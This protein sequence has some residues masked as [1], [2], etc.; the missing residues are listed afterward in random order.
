MEWRTQGLCATCRQRL[1]AG[2]P[3]LG[4][5]LFEG[6]EKCGG[7]LFRRRKA[8]AEQF[9]RL[10]TLGCVDRFIGYTYQFRVVVGRS[11]IEHKTL[12]IGDREI[13]GITFEEILRH[14]AD[15]IAK[16]VWKG[17]HNNPSHG[18]FI[19]TSRNRVFRRLDDVERLCFLDSA[20]FR[21]IWIH[22]EQ[23]KL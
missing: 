16:P 20:Q 7:H 22:Q 3:G 15:C 17:S 12:T 19:L 9:N 6:H 18:P 1:P 10:Y 21:K 2:R 14:S 4:G 5:F 13:K 11:G 23:E 8:P